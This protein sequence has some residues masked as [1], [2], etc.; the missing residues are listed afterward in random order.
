MSAERL[1]PES[2]RSVLVLLLVCVAIYWAY[3]MGFTGAMYYD[4]F[5]P[6]SS[7]TSVKDLNSA[8]YYVLTEESGPLGRPIS[9]LTFL[10]NRDDWDGDKSGFFQINALIH[11]AN[12]LLVAIISWQL[13]RLQGKEGRVASWIALGAAALWMVLPIQVSSSLIAI[14]RMA[15]LAAFFM[16]A[17]LAVYLWGISVQ[18]ERPRQGLFLQL[19]GIGLFTVLAAL[20]KESGALLPVLALVIETTL[21][22]GV[23]SARPW[24]RYR[25][26]ACSLVLFA[27]LAYLV[28]TLGDG[29]MVFEVRGFTVAQRVITEGPILLDYLRLAFIP[30]VYAFRPFHDEYQALPGWDLP[31]ALAMLFWAVVLVGAIKLRCR[32]PVLAFAALWFLASHLLES[33][34]IGLE[35]YFEHRNYFALLG[36]CFA[37]VWWIAKCP[38]RYRSWA[39]MAFGGYIVIMFGVLW[40]VTSLW[41]QQ[42]DAA[43]VWFDSAK[44]SP[45]A[46]EHLALMFLGQN[47]A[48]EAWRV[49][50][51]QTER[52]PDCVGSQVQAMLLSCVMGDEQKTR[53]HYERAM[54]LAATVGQLGSAPSALAATFDQVSSKG[55]KYLSLDDLAA[56]NQAMIRFQVSGISMKQR[57]SL[58]INLQ[59]IAIERERPQE[60]LNY[61]IQAWQARPDPG[62]GEGMVKLWLKLGHVNQAQAFVSTQMCSKLPRNPLLADRQKQ[63]CAAMQSQIDN[64]KKDARSS[65]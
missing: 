2:W 32:S 24:R 40:Q 57:A 61:L 31:S 53:A 50:E 23:A 65:S 8:L 19:T 58:F 34:V 39:A 43:V 28:K 15:S 4:D 10:L 12:G 45:R 47:Q 27:L 59:A 38:E 44:G 20:A 56:L 41:G 63:R 48:Y 1:G 64:A 21:L 54:S 25:I 33:T 3:S 52:C 49:L 62:L 16:F 5:R 17:G 60:A 18:L 55:C 22:V 37:L 51:M 42:K 46:A 36:P 29:Q 13:A 14:Q 6:L 35:L 30:D 7:L 9:M 11:I 26:A